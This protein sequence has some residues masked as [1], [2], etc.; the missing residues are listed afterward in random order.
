MDMFTNIFGRI[1]AA[2]VLGLLLL[3][4]L[5][6]ADVVVFDRITA[7]NRPVF[8]KVLTT[9]TWFAES[10]RRVAISVNGAAAVTILTGGDGYGYLKYQPQE[11]GY[12]TVTATAGDRTDNGRLL[13][14][15]P[16][17]TAALIDIEGALTNTL[18]SDLAERDSREAIEILHRH[19]RVIFLHR[20]LSLRLARKSLHQQ[21]YPS[22]LVLPWNGTDIFETLAVNGVRV[23]VVIGGKALLENAPESIEQRF[24]F[25]RDA[26]GTTVETWEDI[27]KAL[28]SDDSGKK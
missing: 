8:L 24:T 3:P 13:V 26:R 18:L 23:V 22:T 2:P 19:H 25:D 5:A 11:A 16:G 4:T 15:E 7:V 17:E 6:P 21:G 9:G 28:P 1:A 27:L 12:R 14:V 10:G 20:W